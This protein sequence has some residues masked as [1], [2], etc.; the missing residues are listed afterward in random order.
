MNLFVFSRFSHDPGSG[1]AGILSL[2]LV[3]GKFS[4][5]LALCQLSGFVLRLERL[6][7]V[8]A[9]GSYRMI[10]SHQT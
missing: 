8:F 10:E 5:D 2:A 7:A 3:R 9:D 1:L 4:L 6:I